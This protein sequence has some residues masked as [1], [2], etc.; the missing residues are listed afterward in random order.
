MRFTY[1]VD[2][3][4]FNRVI[5]YHYFGFYQKIRAFELIWEV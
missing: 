3:F 1:E 4:D 5:D 2:I